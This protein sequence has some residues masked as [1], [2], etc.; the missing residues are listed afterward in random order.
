MM[1]GSSRPQLK[2]PE[3]VWLRPAKTADEDFLRALFASTREQE[4]ALLP[5]GAAATLFLDSQFDLQHAEYRRSFPRASHEIIEVNTVAAGRLYVDRAEEALR[6]VDISLLP[7]Y[8]GRG[9]GTFLLHRLLA[10]AAQARRALKLSVSI[11]NPAQ[12]LYHR[13]GFK[14]VSS[15]G[16]YLFQEAAP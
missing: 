15:D 13:L 2:T 11:S 14:T 4:L 5:G 9:I 7:A 10:E 8:R 12:R 16:V 6:L 1:R 3:A